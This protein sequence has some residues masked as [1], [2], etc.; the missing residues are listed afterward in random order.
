MEEGEAKGA[1]T[2]GEPM[3]LLGLKITAFFVIWL[4][5][6]IGPSLVSP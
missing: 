4:F 2:T 1:S 5:G 3:S 6:F